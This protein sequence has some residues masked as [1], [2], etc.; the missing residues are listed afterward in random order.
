MSGSASGQIGH[1]AALGAATVV[2]Q[3]SWSATRR[4]V[5]FRFPPEA[6]A[7]LLAIAWWDWPAQ[8][9]IGR[10]ESSYDPVEDFIAAWD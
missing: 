9:A 3:A 2:K 1:G 4:L 10:R 7:R 5:R 6:I 8:A